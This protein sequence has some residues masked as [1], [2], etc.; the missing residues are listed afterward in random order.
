MGEWMGSVRKHRNRQGLNVFLH[1]GPL[2]SDCE[3]NTLWYLTPRP[4]LSSGSACGRSENFGLAVVQLSH[5]TYP[6]HGWTV[7]REEGN[8]PSV[9]LSQSSP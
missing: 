6:L 4:T 3:R 2:L 9:L 8:Y 1:K 5:L 7:W